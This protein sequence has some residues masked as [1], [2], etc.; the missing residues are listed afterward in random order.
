MYVCCIYVAF[1][2]HFR[3]ECIFVAFPNYLHFAFLLY[4]KYLGKT[5]HAHRLDILILGHIHLYMYIHIYIY[6]YYGIYHEYHDG[7]LMTR[8]HCDDPMGVMSGRCRLMTTRVAMAV[9]IA[10]R[11]Q[12]SVS[13]LSP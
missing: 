2:L 6:I 8:W 9:A 13:L 11:K 3:V 10:V 12:T 7:T 4:F 5:G 1:M